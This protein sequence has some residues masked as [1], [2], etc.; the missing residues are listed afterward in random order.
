MAAR[1]SRLLPWLLA[2]KA[3]RTPVAFGVTAILED[4]GGRI[5]LVRQRYSP[6]WHLP[7]GGV[8]RGEPPAEAIIRELQEE[9]GLQSWAAPVLHALYTRAVG[10][11]TNV[12]ALY[13]VGDAVI[14]FRP[15][16]EIAEILWAD[17]HTPPDDA[18]PATLRRFAELVGGATPTPYW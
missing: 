16:R 11:T 15:N 13:R 1:R 18:T 7:G 6:G 5:L 4:A 9:V 14:S 3:L 12:V 8:D 10:V 2:Y 17:P